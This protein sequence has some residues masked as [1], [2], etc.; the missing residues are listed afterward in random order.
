MTS[1]DASKGRAHLPDFASR[2]SNGFLGVCT[3]KWLAAA[4]FIGKNR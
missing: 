2:S 4:Y 1:R 3:K